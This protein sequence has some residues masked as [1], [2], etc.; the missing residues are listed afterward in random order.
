MFLR[1]LLQF[2]PFASRKRKILNPPQ[3]YGIFLRL[4]QSY[5]IRRGAVFRLALD[6]G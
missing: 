1:L 4:R 5:L 6:L 2:L 3:I